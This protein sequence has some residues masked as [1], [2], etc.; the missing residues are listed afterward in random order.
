MRRRRYDF[1]TI[2]EFP[3]VADELPSLLSEL[4]SVTRI[5]YELSDAWVTV[6]V[7]LH[8][9]AQVWN[10]LPTSPTA[11]MSINSANH[12]CLGTRI[13]VRMRELPKRGDKLVCF[14]IRLELDSRDVPESDHTVERLRGF[15]RDFARKAS[16]G[17]YY[18]LRPEGNE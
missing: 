14:T 6:T 1:A 10:S 8:R 9:P 16:Q 7:R 12:A 11:V 13:P 3:E 18:P 5:Q 4:G 17:W 15:I 2:T